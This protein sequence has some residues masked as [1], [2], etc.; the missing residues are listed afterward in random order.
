MI[1][2]DSEGRKSAAGFAFSAKRPKERVGESAQ[3][4]SQ[5]IVAALGKNGLITIE[6][7]SAS[8]GLVPSEESHV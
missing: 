3:K 8:I 4:S 2:Q 5:K 1:L 6:E 7:L